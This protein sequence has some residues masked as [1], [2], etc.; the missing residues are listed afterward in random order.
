VPLK[1]ITFISISLLLQSGAFLVLKFASI[2][3]GR[4]EL[5]LFGVALVFM[6]TRAFVWQ[7][8]LKMAPLS[9]VY[10]FTLLT[11]VLLFFYGVA[12]FNEHY[13][14]YHLLG[15]IIILLGLVVIF[16]EDKKDK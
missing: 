15:L 13:T 11:Q 1:L 7:Q 8:I 5:I 16:Q 3:N 4:M 10:P 2:I 6:L 14:S 12:F 9:R